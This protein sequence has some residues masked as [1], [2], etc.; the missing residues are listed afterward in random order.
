MQQ[1]RTQRDDAIA[2]LEVTDDSGR[3]V[4]EAGDL[5]GAPR[6][7]RRFSFDQPYTGPFARI[8]D[9]A[10]GYLHRRHGAA[11]GYL[12]GDGRAQRRGGYITFQRISSFEGSSMTIGRVRQLAKLCGSGELRSIQTTAAGGAERRAERCRGCE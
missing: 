9:R 7:P 4:A 3:F 2:V 12:D 11:V 5:H 8:E 10:D 1:M 6:D